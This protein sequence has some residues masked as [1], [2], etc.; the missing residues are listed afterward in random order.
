MYQIENL[1]GWNG[2]A[3]RVELP[4]TCGFEICPLVFPHRAIEGR[5]KTFLYWMKIWNGEFD[6]YF[7]TIY[8]N[9]FKKWVFNL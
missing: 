2:R 3:Q 1:N 7:C 6:F 4:S 5:G 8:K 9:Y